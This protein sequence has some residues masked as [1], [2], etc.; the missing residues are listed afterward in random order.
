MKLVESG[1][2]LVL[3]SIGIRPRYWSVSLWYFW[4][5]RRPHIISGQLVYYIKH[6]PLEEKDQ[7]ERRLDFADLM[8]RSLCREV[9]AVQ[10]HLED[11]MPERYM[12]TFL[13]D[14]L[15]WI[16]IHHEVITGEE[17]NAPAAPPA[18]PRAPTD[19]SG[20]KAAKA[21]GFD[22]LSVAGKSFVACIVWGGDRLSSVH[23][24]NPCHHVKLKSFRTLHDPGICLRDVLLVDCSAKRNS[25]NHPYSAVH[26]KV[27]DVFTSVPEMSTW[28]LRFT[29]C[30]I[31]WTE[32]ILPIV[33]F[34]H[35][36]RRSMDGI[37]DPI[38]VLRD[39]WEEMP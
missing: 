19:P 28:L 6:F 29:D 3:V 24:L 18:V 39:F 5:N 30:L 34:V 27:V 13:A 7:P 14:S 37:T 16:L 35:A 2:L 9:F 36:H 4:A 17:C 26:P 38:L 31:T 20:V 1:T 10:A 15:T 33:E 21:K 11:E 12:E 25:L 23:P 22:V 32:N 8:M